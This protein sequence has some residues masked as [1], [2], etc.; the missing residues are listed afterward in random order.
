[1]NLRKTGSAGQ[2]EKSALVGAAFLTGAS[3]I[4]PGFLVQTSLFT[5]QFGASMGAVVLCTI[6]LDIAV[7]SNVWRVIGAA[8][9][10]GQDIANRLLP[11]LGHAVAVLVALGGLL[12]SVGNV[13]GAALGLNALAGLPLWAGYL[14]SSL[15]AILIFL[16]KNARAGIDAASKILSILVLA[17]LLVVAFLAKPPMGRV[18][19]KLFLPDRTA[20]LLFPMIT[21]LGGASGGYISYSGAHRLL[22]SGFSGQENLGR[23]QKSVLL[24]AA[25]TG[26]SR[27]LI[28]LVALG[29]CSGGGAAA[30]A[31]IAGAENPAGEAFRRAAGEFGYRLFGV[32]LFS[33]GITTIIGSSY[34]SVSFL[35]TLHPVIEKQEK[36]FISGFIAL[37]AAMMALLGNASSLLVAA[38]S[39]NGLILP[40]TM[41]VIFAASHSRR[42]VGRTYRH[43]PALTAAGILVLLLTGY[44][45][46]RALP[47]LA[48]IFT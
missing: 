18:A 6:L 25:I 35:K 13:G 33:A 41:G 45:G 38:G 36:W 48:A 29:V 12:F 30:A 1:M 14:V 21:L 5:A 20:E 11:G 40:V 43:P 8:G 23:I 46:I 34:T 32:A 4:G 2:T 3:S 39:V 42:I 22:D 37:S 10:R 26:V 27:I 24:A 31:A 28:F 47:G 7:K 19:E 15:L 16:S 9:I 17:V 44:A